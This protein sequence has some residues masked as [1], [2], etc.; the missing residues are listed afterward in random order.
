MT[1]PKVRFDAQQPVIYVAG[2]YRAPHEW[3]VVQNIRNAELIAV[4][5]WAEGFAVICPHKNTALFGGACQD[6]VWLQGDLAI[7][8]RCDVVYEMPGCDKST[9]A[10]GELEFARNR[11]IPVVRSLSEATAWRNS[12]RRSPSSGTVGPQ[13]SG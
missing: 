3:G 2:P 9:G 11:G 4:D 5:L 12:H 1:T 8:A 6:S 13:S 10:T 7:L